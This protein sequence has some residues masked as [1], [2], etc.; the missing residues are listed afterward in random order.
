MIKCRCLYEKGLK[1]KAKQLHNKIN[2]QDCFAFSRIYD[3]VFLPSEYT[4][5]V[6][7]QIEKLKYKG[8]FLTLNQ[9]R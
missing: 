6:H 5:D 2:A 9:K 7:N 8:L 1:T 4:K 3:Q